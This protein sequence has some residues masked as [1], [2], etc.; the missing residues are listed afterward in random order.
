MVYSYYIR[1]INHNVFHRIFT[2]SVNVE[3]YQAS[4]FEIINKT[5]LTASTLS[6][7]TDYTNC[8]L[9]FEIED[10]SIM[11]NFLKSELGFLNKLRFAVVVNSEEN[12]L[13]LSLWKT[14][15]VLHGIYIQ[16]KI[17]RHEENA[18]NFIGLNI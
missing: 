8:R 14:E 11:A 9:M 4:W 16:A 13:K 6:V 3:T 12:H 18:F 5:D 7:V 2:G 10:Y 15:L 17:C 1:K